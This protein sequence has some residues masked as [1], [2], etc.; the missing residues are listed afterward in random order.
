MFGFSNTSDNAKI[1][2]APTDLKL[3]SQYAIVENGSGFSRLDN[4][5]APVDLSENVTLR[6]NKI[7][8]VGNSLVNH[9]PST[10]KGGVQYLVKLDALQRT[11]N[12]KTGVSVD[13]P[14]TVQITFRHGLSSNITAPVVESLLKRA[15]GALYK[16]D[17]T[18]RITDL[19][20][21]GVEIDAD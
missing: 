4:K 2:I 18:S 9:N 17:G 16:S 8:N 10:V 20:R 19:M 15:I 13:E 1:T 12:E 7:N 11:T 5:T 6:Y 14:I 3:K 21:G